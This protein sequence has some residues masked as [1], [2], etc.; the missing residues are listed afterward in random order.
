MKKSFEPIKLRKNS[1]ERVL[2]ELIN[3]NEIKGKNK[4]LAEDYSDNTSANNKAQRELKPHNRKKSRVIMEFLA[5]AAVIAMITGLIAFSVNRS[6]NNQTRPL[7][8]S[9]YAENS[10]KSGSSIQEESAVT[11]MVEFISSEKLY[12]SIAINRQYFSEYEINSDGSILLFQNDY[13]TETGFNYNCIKVS[14]LPLSFEEAIAEQEN[15]IDDYHVLS[16]TENVLIGHLLCDHSSDTD[17]SVF[18]SG[19]NA[20]KLSC[21]YD[22]P[23]IDVKEY[24][25]IY[26][27]DS[28]TYSDIYGAYIITATYQIFNSEGDMQ[29]STDPKVIYDIIDTFSFMTYSKKTLYIL[30]KDN[31]ITDNPQDDG[32]DLVNFCKEYTTDDEYSYSIIA[33]SDPAGTNAEFN[34]TLPV[35]HLYDS[36][37]TRD[38]ALSDDFYSTFDDSIAIDLY[39]SY[40]EGNYDGSEITAIYPSFGVLYSEFKLDNSD[41]SNNTNETEKETT[42]NANTTKSFKVSPQDNGLISIGDKYC[43]INGISEAYEEQLSQSSQYNNDN[44]FNYDYVIYVPIEKIYDENG[45]Q[46][47]NFLADIAYASPSFT[48]TVYYDGIVLESFPAQ[49]YADKVIIHELQTT[50]VYN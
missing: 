28:H 43:T 13:G 36:S 10:S 18:S 22:L 1:R 46:I 6:G 39:Y 41:N 23:D 42:T 40:Y 12:A 31:Y 21:S 17:C 4:K 37:G 9:D 47:G 44:P 24:K 11:P 45:N 2:R 30:P 50:N 32:A 34:I 38:T 27:I 49:I 14:A 26:I 7:S 35:G 25:D 19:I 16:K 3:Y 29:Y 8:K 48:M 20:T 15:R 33:S 5:G